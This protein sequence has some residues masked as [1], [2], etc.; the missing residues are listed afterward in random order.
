MSS[1][2][3]AQ[4]RPQ[5]LSFRLS[6]GFFLRQLSIFFCMDF[7]LLLMG[8]GGL[9]FWGESR[10]AQVAA[11]VAE[12]GIPSTETVQW[13]EA[14]DYS[15]IPINRDASWFASNHFP[16]FIADCFPTTQDGVRVSDLTTHYTI[17]LPNG[18][19]PYAIRVEIA[20]ISRLLHFVFIFLLGMQGFFLVVG[21]F[22]NNRS[23]HRT[24]RP[25]QDLAATAVR[26]NSVG[27]MSRREMEALTGE[28]EKIT[29][30]HLD[31]RIDLPATQR[32]LRTLASAI[33]AMLDRVNKAYATQLQFVSDASHEL[34][35]PI[36]V[37][38]GY[39]A[40]LD[41]WGKS[42]P[43]TRQ[44]AIDAIRSESISMQ[45]LVEQ[46]LFLARGD[47]DSQ[48]VQME[49]FNLTELGAEVLRDETIVHQERI[50]LPQW[51]GDINVYGDPALLKQ[52]MRILM[53]N[54][55]KYSPD[56]GRIWLKITQLDGRVRVTVQD[57]GMGIPPEAL[58]HI[59]NRFYRSD[60][61]RT[62]QTGGTGLGLSI[63]RWIV[64]YHDGWFEITSREGFGTRFSFLLPQK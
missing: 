31:N 16:D 7:L 54:S 28:L 48:P 35:T 20:G 34:R 4:P 55:V 57:E 22:G 17:E 27:H 46:L 56:D 41:R 49:A 26:L 63:A 59:F 18:E 24:L 30:T 42:D 29:A 19:T 37:I 52:V 3:Q 11:L 32:E 36:A 14:V 12:R 51:D 5:S 44:E 23:I 10:C 33:N 39:S 53:D 45:H 58:P 8:V 1:E 62:R 21:L 13:M 15:I 43:E 25:I 61:S 47:N 6:S 9:F 2:S 40:L 50:F 60:A 38:Q 64:D